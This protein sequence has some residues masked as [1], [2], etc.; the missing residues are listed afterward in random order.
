MSALARHD[1]DAPVRLAALCR[2]LRASAGLGHKRDIAWALAALGDA[3]LP[4]APNGDD[5]AALPD[6]DGWL[7][8]A[9]EGFINDFV[10]REPWFAGWCGVMVN[11]SDIAAM[12]GRPMAVVNAVWAEGGEAMAQVLAGMA[13][14]A[15]CY[16]VPV[17]GGHSNARSERGQLAVSILGRADHLLSGFAA[18]PGHRLM[19]AVDLRGGYR[20]GFPHWDA[21]TAAP[22]TRLRGDLALLPELAREGHCVAARDISQAGV[23]G[24]LMMLCE[25]SGVGATVDIEAVPLP[26]NVDRARWLLSTFPS[27]GFLM[28]V[29]P[30]REAEVAVAFAGRDIACAA[31]GDF[32]ADRVLTLTSGDARRTAW[33]FVREP[34]TGCRG[35]AMPPSTPEH[36]HA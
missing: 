34:V 12:G 23:L 7:L 3:G 9:I 28:A 22:P 30:E 24:S 10:A 29:P 14:A 8:F 16:G 31:V 21:A 27:Y 6:G 36:V 18:R 5:C 15:R 25:G 11:C 17:V 13:A 26:G 19:V 4:A 20:D 32:T 2:E 33:D 1:D 35:A